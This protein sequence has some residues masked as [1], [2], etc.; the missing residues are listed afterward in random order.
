MAYRAARKERGKKADE[1]WQGAADTCEGAFREA[2]GEVG[3]PEG[4]RGWNE[5]KD[6]QTHTFM[7]FEGH[8]KR[9]YLYDGHRVCSRC[10]I[11][12]L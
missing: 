10:L 1:A 5:G 9:K 11:L 4:Q 3:G 2:G 7:N 8:A 12:L 6:Y